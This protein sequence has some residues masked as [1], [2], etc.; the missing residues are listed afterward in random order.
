MT[1]KRQGPTQGIRS[2]WEVSFGRKSTVTWCLSP[3]CK[4]VITEK[5]R[6]S[7]A[8]SLC[9]FFSRTTANVQQEVKKKIKKN[10]EVQ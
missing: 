5:G 4:D 10:N 8:A 2:S 6:K 9:K 3:V 7:K 1:K